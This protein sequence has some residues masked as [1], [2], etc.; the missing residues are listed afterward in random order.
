MARGDMTIAARNG[1]LLPPGYGLDASG[2]PTCDPAEALS[3]AQLPFAGHKGTAIALMIELLAASLSGDQ[4]AFEA[5]ATDNNDGGPTQH[6]EM[7]IA[8]DPAR[9]AGRP[10]EA[11]LSRVEAL[12]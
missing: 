10:R 7:I 4:F 2:T 9:S 11:F 3:G 8:I 12:F 5:K 6:G 1:K